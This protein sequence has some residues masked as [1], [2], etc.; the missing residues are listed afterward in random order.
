M[1]AMANITYQRTVNKGHLPYMY[2]KVKLELESDCQVTVL[3][4]KSTIVAA[5][6]QV[7]G[8]IG[9]SFVFDILQYWEQKREAIIRVRY[10]DFVKLQ[11]SLTMCGFYSGKPC[12]FRLLQ[13]SSHLIGL[14]VNSRELTVT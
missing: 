13:V 6:K 9:S 10:S 14:A 5:V 4:F 8:E 7:F 1:S 3:Y 11:S 2:L 12:A